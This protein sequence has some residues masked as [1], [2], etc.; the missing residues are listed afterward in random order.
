M[1]SG[2]TADQK[3]VPVASKQRLPAAEPPNRYDVQV[4]PADSFQRSQ[5]ACLGD[6]CRICERPLD[7]AVIGVLEGRR[8]RFTTQGSFQRL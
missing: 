3:H 8:E 4:R 1:I 6:A 7:V 2:F 5:Q